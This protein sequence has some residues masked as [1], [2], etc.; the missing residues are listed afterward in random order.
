MRRPRGTRDLFGEELARI[1]HVERVILDIFRRYGYQEVETPV[2]ESLELFTKK[3]GSSIVDQ[4]YAFKDKSGRELALRPELTAPVVRLYNEHLR[5][6]PKPLKL[7]YLGHCFRYERPQIGRG[8][9]RQFLQAGCEIIGSSRPEAD[10]EVVALTAEIV[11]ELGIKKCE[12]RLGNVRL[13]REVLKRAGVSETEQDPIMR[14]IDSRDEIRLQAELDRWGIEEEDKKLLKSLISLRGGEKVLEDVRELI[15]GLPEATKALEK[16]KSII[17]RLKWFGVHKFSIDFGISRGLEYY[18]DF[19][20]ELYSGGIQL[21]GGGRYDNL[22]EL[23]GGEPCPA[24]GVGLGVDRIADALER[25]G[26]ETPEDRLDCMVLPTTDEI[27]GEALRIAGELRRAGFSADV[28]LMGRSLSKGLSY[29]NSRK[30]KFAVVVGPRDLKVG[31]V[32][33]RK[34]KSGEQER[35]DRKRLTE[36]LSLG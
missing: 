4:I 24:V 36:F 30:A 13:L 26:V 6:S 11:E 20:F 34:M 3:S 16:T 25:H 2:F 29:A 14:A 21:G 10:A 27:I 9:Y 19:V 23:L 17:D 32:T 5:S 35:V 22:I 18:T 33:I 28:D 15:Q 12:L 8:R 31:K 7:F 1:R